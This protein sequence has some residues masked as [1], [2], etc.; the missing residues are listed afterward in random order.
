M[1]RLHPTLIR[2]ANVIGLIAS[3][4]ILAAWGT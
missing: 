2:W 3:V 1:G 4:V